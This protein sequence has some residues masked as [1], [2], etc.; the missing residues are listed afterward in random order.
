MAVQGGLLRIQGNEGVSGTPTAGRVGEATESG[1]G[2]GDYLS[3]PT[4][5]MLDGTPYQHLKKAPSC[6]TS[7]HS[8]RTGPTRPW[9]GSRTASPQLKEAQSC[10][11]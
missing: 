10:V 5:G 9:P 11:T 8:G 2:L 3:A 4:S 6:P 7:S 1:R